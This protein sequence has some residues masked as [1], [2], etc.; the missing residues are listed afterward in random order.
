MDNNEAERMQGSIELYGALTGNCIRAAIAL[1]EAGIPYAVKRVNLAAGEQRSEQH[2]V[3]NAFGKV[4]VLVEYR[5]GGTFVLTQSNAIMLFAAE[6]S[7][8][9]L[10]PADPVARARVYERFFYFVTDVIAVSHGAFRL[11]QLG[12]NAQAS[13]INDLA[14]ASLIEAERFLE[15]TAFMAGDMFSL[16]DIAAFTITKAFSSNIQ[17]AD[18]P[19][20]MQWY[21]AVA[22]RPGVSHGLKAFESETASKRN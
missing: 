22:R 13:L 16:A 20:L 11:E 2:R 10:M 3:L 7:K 8:N 21:E 19:A 12:A 1:D 18:H 17:W 5:D 14:R 15:S 6:R 4:P 9:T